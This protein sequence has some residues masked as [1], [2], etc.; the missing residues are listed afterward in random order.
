MAGVRDVRQ[1]AK[2]ISDYV[3]GAEVTQQSLAAQCVLNPAAIT[4]LKRGHTFPQLATYVVLRARVPTQEQ[5]RANKFDGSRRD[6]PR[7]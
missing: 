5:M 4:R 3:N 6:L 2:D 1:L 7:R